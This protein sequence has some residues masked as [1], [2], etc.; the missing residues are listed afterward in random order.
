VVLLTAAALV[1]GAVVAGASGLVTPAGAVV[2]VLAPPWPDAE[3]G[4]LPE[5]PPEQAASATAAAS[6]SAA[7]SARRGG[8]R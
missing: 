4:E 3:A 1:G 6:A 8:A 7:G 5:P 2:A